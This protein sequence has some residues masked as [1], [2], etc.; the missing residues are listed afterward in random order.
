MLKKIAKAAVSAFSRITADE[1]F[2][3]AAQASFYIVTASI[4]F[5]TE[6]EAVGMVQALVPGM[7]RS[8]VETI[9]RELF[10]KSTAI[11]SI[12]GVTAVWSA[13]R[14]IAAVERGVKKVYKTK[15][16]KGFFKSI[17]FSVFYTVL[18][19]IALLATL[20][21]MVFGG[22]I[23]SF[24]SEHWHWLVKMEK[25]MGG[26]REL[27]YFLGLS[28]F[29]SFV[30]RVFAGKGSK[31]KNQIF[32]ALFTTMGWFLFSYV[33]SIYVENFAN[34]SYVYGSLTMLVLMMLW[35]Y[36]CMIILLLGAEVNVYMNNR[37]GME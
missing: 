33:F 30:Y 8:S 28:I 29:F 1:I 35:L 3:Y 36:S 32:G 24:A 13:S 2:M 27:M 21:L 19:I 22:T 7:L 23:Y 20:L 25:W 12:T 4:P 11:I 31:V 10:I 15:K 26:A 18:F 6:A 17:A 37:K 34:Y 16:D 14:G 9:I 5:M